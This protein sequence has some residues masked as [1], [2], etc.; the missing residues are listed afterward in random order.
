MAR[1][2]RRLSVS[3][4]IA[5]PPPSPAAPPDFVQQ[6][7]AAAVAQTGRPARYDGSYRR[8]PY[9]GG[10]VPAGVGVCTDVVIRAYRAAGVDLQQRVHEDMTRA[11]AA[12]PRLWG[13]ERPDA[14]ID[15]RRV[16]NL[17][18]Y[19]RR[20]GA[21]ATATRDPRDYAAGDLVT[22]MLPGNLP[23]IGL[24]SDR[25]SAD[26]ERPLIVHNIGNGPEIEDMLF[27]F[28]ITG[29]YRYR[30]E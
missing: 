14:N 3:A 26:G 28:T 18:T 17:Q 7:I 27:A 21:Q 4:L 30:G 11:F 8:I 1:A 13:L 2:A 25:R 19:F 12:Y 10:D 9:P 15:H 5:L 22:W 24:V 6:V 20:K 16:P 23:H 29:H